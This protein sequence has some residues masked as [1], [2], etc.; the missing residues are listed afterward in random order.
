LE[1]NTTDIVKFL[2]VNRYN[3]DTV[4]FLIWNLTLLTSL[5]F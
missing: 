4:K 3:T 5:S 1:L 2:S